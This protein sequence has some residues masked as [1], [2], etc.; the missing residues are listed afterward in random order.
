MTTGASA[1]SSKFPVIV[2]TH[3]YDAP[4]DEVFRAWIEPKHIVHWFY[5]SEGWTTPFAETDIRPGGAF[6]IGFASPDGKN[7][8]VFEGAYDEITPPERLVFTIGD[9]RPIVVAF[10]EENGK[11]KLSLELALESTHSEE[12]QRQGWGAMLDH[13]AE[14]LTA[15]EPTSQTS[16]D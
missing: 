2:L 16:L 7:D 14:Y 10:T 13:L 4:R 6:R 15:R 8:F 3:I 11:T 9:G 5:A 12:Q 1:K